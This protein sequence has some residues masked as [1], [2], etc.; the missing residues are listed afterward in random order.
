LVQLVALFKFEK[1]ATGRRI[2]CASPEA[3]K[4]ASTLPL[5]MKCSDLGRCFV[6]ASMSCTEVKTVNARQIEEA[7]CRRS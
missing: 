3:R 1:K 7:C 4:H 5:G 2:A 6:M